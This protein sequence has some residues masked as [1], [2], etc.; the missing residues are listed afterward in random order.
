[1]LVY[2]TLVLRRSPVESR[3]PSMYRLV[4][5]KRFYEVW[6]RP[7]RSGRPLLEHLPL[8]SD[9]QSAAAPNCSDVLRLAK[10][11]G[12][13]GLL[14]TVARPAAITVPLG[15]GSVPERWGSGAGEVVPAGEGTVSATANVPT[16]GRYGVWLGGSFRDRLELLVDDRRVA[17]RRNQL[18]NASQYTPLMSVELGPGAHVF[19][20]HYDG[21]DLHPGSG[22]PQFPM[23][24]LV[25]GSTPADFPLT[26]VRSAKARTLCGRNLD[27]IEALGS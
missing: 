15:T 3:P 19:A 4:W 18:N 20:I 14:A 6:Q 2:R 24:P 11:A 16:R 25:L 26:Y 10:R 23:G 13:G 21:P 27:W 7:R 17:V 1:V 22:G 5:R 12:S 8:G 9:S